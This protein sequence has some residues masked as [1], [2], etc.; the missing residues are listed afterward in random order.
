MSEWF[1]SLASQA[2]QLADNLAETISTTAATASDELRQEQLK[3]QAEANSRKV[4][5][6][7]DLVLPW[8]T[9]DESLAILSQD[10]MEK[11]FKLSLSERNFITGPS[12]EKP[13]DPLSIAMNDL[14]HDF[15]MIFNEY[16]PTIM[17][18]LELDS[19]LS[20][21]HAKLSPKM[22]NEED[23]WNHYYLRTMYLRAVAGLEGKV[24]QDKYRSVTEE[25]IV[26][27]PS[28]DADYSRRKV[29]K[30]QKDATVKESQ[31]SDAKK[32][33]AK[34]KESE[35]EKAAL[36]KEVEE[37]LRDEDIDLTDLNDLEG[38]D[39]E[40]ENIDDTDLDDEADLEA[41]I[42]RELGRAEEG[43]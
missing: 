40:F 5:K 27:P 15:P 30:E 2:K 37:E 6:N 43:D 11:V 31:E 25:S 38:A 4:T 17:K 19:N 22:K 9:K 7:A 42:A 20:H 32:A 23:F 39:D 1:A 14:A 8:E 28:F 12:T 34:Q 26:F 24:F 16:V 10:L 3:I 33:Q 13:D 35:D 41:Q 18:L 36:A 21:M 29:E